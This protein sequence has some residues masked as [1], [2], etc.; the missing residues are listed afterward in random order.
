MYLFSRG[1][2]STNRLEH[3]SKW[4][5]PTAGINLCAVS[6]VGISS[7]DS[8]TQASRRAMSH[9]R[10]CYMEILLEDASKNVSFSL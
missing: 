3:Y 4:E 1:S 2:G 6:N 9:D 7:E 8:D 5:D 10:F